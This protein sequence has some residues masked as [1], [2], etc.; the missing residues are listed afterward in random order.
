[1]AARAHAFAVTA[2]DGSRQYAFCR[3]LSALHALVVL[4]DCSHTARFVSALEAT[5]DRFASLLLIDAPAHRGLYRAQ[6]PLSHCLSPPF[7]RAS[8]L[9]APD[10]AHYLCLSTVRAMA[11]PQANGSEPCTM[12]QD[13]SKLASDALR[14]SP[15]SDFAAHD[16]KPLQDAQHTHASNSTLCLTPSSTSSGRVT[17]GSALFPADTLTVEQITSSAAAATF[18]SDDTSARTLALFNEVANIDDANSAATEDM[19]GHLAHLAD[20][21]VLF[22]NFSVRSIVVMITALLEERH[23]CIVGPSSSLVSRAV[24]AVKDL[25]Y[26]FEWPHILSPILPSHHLQVLG[27]P[28]PFL[29]GILDEFYPQALELPLVEGLVF[30]NVQTGKVAFYPEGLDISRHIPRRLRNRLERRLA[31]VK[32]ACTRSRLRLNRSETSLSTF[33]SALSSNSDQ[34]DDDA[35]ITAPPMSRPATLQHEDY[36]FKSQSSAMWRSRPQNRLNKLTGTGQSSLDTFISTETLTALHKAMCK[37][38]AELLADLPVIEGTGGDHETTTNGIVSSPPP[39]ASIVLSPASISKKDSRTLLRSFAQTQMYMQWERDENRDATFGIIPSDGTRHRRKR[40]ADARDRTTLRARGGV[41][42]AS[43]AEEDVSQFVPSLVARNTLQLPRFKKTRPITDFLDEDAEDPG[44]L[45][46]SETVAHRRS[47]PFA[48]MRILRRQRNEMADDDAAILSQGNPLWFGRS[49]AVVPDVTEAL[50]QDEDLGVMSGPE[51]RMVRK[52]KNIKV[53]RKSNRARRRRN[54]NGPHVNFADEIVS[55]VDVYAQE[56]LTDAEVT[57]GETGEDD[58]TQLRHSTASTEPGRNSD[59]DIG[60]RRPWLFL[61]LPGSPWTSTRES[62]SRDGDSRGPSCDKTRVESSDENEA[63][64]SLHEHVEND[65]V[66][67]VVGVHS[68][69]KKAGEV[70]TASELSAED[71]LNSSPGWKIVRQWQMRRYKNV[72]RA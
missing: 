37:F 50:F 63:A 24:L 8:I 43:D 27:A 40:A 46:G 19:R 66:D 23:V 3:P 71:D 13:E 45:S 18:P 60:V 29:V 54:R 4:A 64:N 44:I 57:V 47:N 12:P 38:F 6:C 22:S 11:S 34:F 30:A 51:P 17:P 53:V 42:D 59:V 16:C 7:R 21:Y 32:S 9:C 41:D 72:A 25:L 14:M 35:Y 2:G 69:K 70:K 10:V 68:V 56:M 1:M 33:M 55:S 58:E 48:N 20:A 36:H 62:S 28:I 67:D 5:V 26:P 31:R 39:I 61:R 15:L 65:I 49:R 52:S